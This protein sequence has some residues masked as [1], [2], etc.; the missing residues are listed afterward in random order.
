M[1]M[2]PN[3][4]KE[5][6]STLLNG[7][8]AACILLVL[9]VPAVPTL[10]SHNASAMPSMTPR[11]VVAY[12]RTARPGPNGQRA[13]IS[14]IDVSSYQGGSIN[15]GTVYSDGNDFAFAR[16]VEY[17]GTP[18]SD[19]GTNMVNGKAAGVYMG[20]YDFVYP[21]SE[22]ATT[23]ADYFNG[24]IKTYVASGYVYPALDLEEDCTAS[25]G[26]MS[27]SQI[28]AWVNSW[29]TEMQ[30]DLSSD[31]YSGVVPI[32]Y[33]NSNYAANCVDASTW[34]GWT[35][36]IA[37]YYNTCATSPNPSTGVLSSWAFWQWC[38]TGSSGG[39]DPVDQD[40]FNGDL[41]QLQSGYVFGGG[42]TTSPTVSYA[43]QDETTS[44]SLSCGGT[45]ATGD[46]IQFTA[47]VTGGTAPYT[48]AWTFG[49]GTNGTGN[50]VTHVYG[51]AGSVTPLL[52]VTDKN[53]KQGSTGTG[54]TFTVTGVSLSSVAVS[55]TAPKVT[56]GGK[57]AFTATATCSSTCP[58]GVAYAWTLTSPG[59]GSI[60][61]ASGASTTFTAGSTA[62]TVG[63]F[64]NATLYGVT[65]KASAVITVTAGPT[66]ITSVSVVP[67]SPSVVV[68]SVTGFTATP[69]CST[70][71]P[72]T[73][74][75]YAWALTS[76]TLGSIS[77]ASGLT[78]SFTA[79][80][81]VGTVGLYVN[82]TL[83]GTTVGTSTVIT[84]TTLPITIISVAV[85]PN[86]PA[87]GISSAT[88]F[89]ATPTCS[90][91]CPATGITYAWALTSTTLGSINLSAGPTT[92]FTAVTTA[93]TVGIYVN[94]TLGVT[95]VSTSTVIT[96]TAAAITLKSVSVTPQ[97]PSV[98]FS[99]TQG[100]TANTTCS[101]TCPKTGITFVW[102]LTSITLGSIT[103]TSGAS[104]TFTAGTTAVTGGIFVNATLGSS[105][106][107][108]YTVIT[109][110]TTTTN[111]L[112]SVSISPTTASVPSGNTQAFTA[113]ARCTSTCPT[114]EVTYVWTLTN[115]ALGKINPTSGT[116][117]TF[118]AGSAAMTGGIF[119]NATLNGTT[120]ESSVVVSV[121]VETSTVVLSGVSITPTAIDLSTGSSQK[122]MATPACKTSGGSSATC[123]S[124]I[125][126]VWSM[127]GNEGNFTP[128]TGSSTTF[129]A[130]SST[131]MVNLTVDAT[132]NGASAHYVATITVSS[133]PGPTTFIGLSGDT[134]YILLA[135]LLA[136]IVVV[137]VALVVHRRRA[138]RA[139]WDE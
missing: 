99:G 26:S 69:K 21:S 31:G 112:N 126:Y 15:W 17:Y 104:T 18:D 62:G 72:S 92:T 129:T 66:T 91:T 128:T 98:P 44:K 28:T 96:V 133:A 127:N 58:S 79:G 4:L 16:A 51:T 46:T 97:L 119:V 36:W 122:F 138:S 41:S 60:S 107:A 89:T 93:G 2:V 20:A 110:T 120:K 75:T 87:V 42:G 121:T 115:T 139:P 84:V 103:P 10:G 90:A 70:T 117:T 55:P 124:G 3:L 48:Y 135:V 77:P 116:T 25:G 35:L 43:M 53:G 27:A 14:G 85:S 56:A 47:T 131:G 37:E 39:I 23:D 49:D 102:A 40:I 1:N 45:F 68:S 65:H 94:A 67:T 81:T 76:T 30:T 118:T 114:P 88:S 24:I 12:D 59:L 71:C 74:I 113:A 100:F 5:R 111:S 13:T 109:V 130:G 64:V 95:T 136:V 82:A 63:L 83:N 50:P 52:T 29:A 86:A 80:T 11:T 7:V 125:A 38:S 54:C 137:A 78:T 61:S 34:G 22:T 123:P 8:L 19:F 57:Q 33:M 106:Q 101:A 6:D 108:T 132:L 9:V 32:V 134:G 73:G 105:T